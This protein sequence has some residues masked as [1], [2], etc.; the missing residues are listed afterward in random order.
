MIFNDRYTRILLQLH[1]KMSKKRGTS[2]VVMVCNM[3]K[4]MNSSIVNLFGNTFDMNVV[5]LICG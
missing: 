1:C 4:L 5:K 3:E 2:T